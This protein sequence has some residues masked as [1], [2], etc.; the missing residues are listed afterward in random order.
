MYQTLLLVLFR[1]KATQ[2][3]HNIQLVYNSILE[4]QY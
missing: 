4:G 2:F 3:V 1:V